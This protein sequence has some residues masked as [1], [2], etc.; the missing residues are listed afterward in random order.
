VLTV[1]NANSRDAER[2]LRLE[3]LS[4]PLGRYDGFALILF[5]LVLVVVAL[6]LP[7]GLALLSLA[8]AFADRRHS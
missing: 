8:M 5:G 6:A 2:R 3:R 1:A 4:G 7:T